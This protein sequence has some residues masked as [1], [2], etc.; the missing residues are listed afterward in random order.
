MNA[1]RVEVTYTA[2]GMPTGVVVDGRSLLVP[3]YSEVSVQ[4]LYSDGRRPL[5]TVRLE[6]LA[7]DVTFTGPRSG[8]TSESA[9]SGPLG[10]AT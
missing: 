10:G 2:E 4:C 7:D 6:I 3:L 1:H 9:V 8:E 5:F